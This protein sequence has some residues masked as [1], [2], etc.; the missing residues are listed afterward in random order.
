M[1]PLSEVLALLDVRNALLARLEAG[2]DWAIDFPRYRHV[3]FGVV[4]RGSCFYQSESG[5]EPLRLTEG[6]CYLL[7]DG[8]PYRLVS[9]PGVEGTS[10]REVFA[11]VP[12]DHVVRLGT[13]SGTTAATVVVGGR[14]VFDQAHARVLLD[15]LP[16][17]IRVA[18][19]TVPADA[20]RSQLRQLEQETT[21]NEFGAALVTERI[22]HIMLV[23]TLRA[24]VSAGGAGGAWL[25]ALHDERI[26]AALAK[27]H[28]R[29]L[30]PWTVAGLATEVGMSRS[31]F[32]TRFT[33]L[34]GTSPLNYLLGW[35]MRTAGREL[36]S[37]RRNI[38]D[39][40]QEWGYGSESAFSNAF[41]RVMGCS[42]GRY[43]ATA[44]VEHDLVTP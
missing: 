40:A 24:H 39:I 6:D 21:H 25:T 31:A 18:A 4:L 27:I 1:D 3:K 33:T 19:D 16:P 20:M 44:E 14:F 23:Q 35:R 36:R 15:V 17:V 28:H 26:G 12:A 30:H 13:A 41:K 10:A 2:G 29:P 7:G 11:D 37:S 32:A 42:P 43:R 34:V 9:A 8:R 38:A 22:A 5:A